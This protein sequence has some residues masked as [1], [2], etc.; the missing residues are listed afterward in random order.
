MAQCKGSTTMFCDFNIALTAS[1]SPNCLS[2]IF[3]NQKDSVTDL[4]DFRFKTNVLPTAM[5]ELSPS[6]LLLYKTTLLALDCAKG[7]QILKGCFFCVVK[8]PCRCSVTA[9]NLYLPPRLGKCN[10]NTDDITILHPV[11]LALLQQF[12]HKDSHSTIFGDTIFEE[13]VHIQLPNFHIFNHSFSQYLAND[14]EQH[15]SLKRIA[16]AVRHDGKVFKSLAESMIAGQVEF[17]VDQWPDTSGI[18]AIIATSIGFFGFT[19]SMWSCYKIRTVLLP[20]L[21]LHQ[22]H[23]AAA[24]TPKPSLSFIYNQVPEGTSPPSIDEHIYATFTTPWP[25]VSLSVLTTILVIACI[26]NLWQRFQKSH[27]TSLHLEI[28]TG[29]TCE[30]FTL[31]TLPL[32]PH[33]WNIQT[34][35]DVS[36]IH[37]TTSYLI[38]CHLH[39]QCNEFTITNIHTNRSIDVPTN[40]WISPLTA[41]KIRNILKHPYTAYFLLSH[42]QYFKIL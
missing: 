19:F 26:T 12:F 24:L 9:N 7:Q 28:T 22:T 1:A 42:H 15:L 20:V 8:I 33:N 30:L 36:S 27:R 35:T 29:P 31:L 2:A 4:C 25:Y 3:F 6:H 23:S 13:L 39:I 10:N 40:I 14:K 38:I 11:N 32:C 16:K 34:P 17:A 21:L 41:R 5:F 37:I 18:L